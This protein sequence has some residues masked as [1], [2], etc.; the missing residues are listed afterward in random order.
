MIKIIISM[1]KFLLPL[2]HAAGEYSSTITTLLDDV[3][4]EL[5]VYIPLV[6]GGL[7]VV[8]ALF[9]GIKLIIRKFFGKKP[10]S[11]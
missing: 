3:K 11:L 8:F 9:W 7:V 2:A 10:I 4:D 1:I 6:L 5:L